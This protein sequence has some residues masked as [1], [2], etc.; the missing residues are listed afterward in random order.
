MC[1]RRHIRWGGLTLVLLLAGV[2]PVLAQHV[3]FEGGLD[4]R[5]TSYRSGHEAAA[6]VNTVGLGVTAQTTA[7]LIGRVLLQVEGGVDYLGP[8]CYDLG[9]DCTARRAAMTST[10]VASGAIGTG[11]QLPLLGTQALGVP[12]AGRVLLGREWLAG[13]IGADDCLNCATD[14]EL[15]G[16]PFLEGSLDVAAQPGLYLRLGYRTYAGSDRHGQ[17]VL[18][19]VAQQ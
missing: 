15:D 5:A 7:R 16:G 3:A 13:G 14:L 10:F 6:E 4:L 1:Y 18:G 17:V 19:V 2:S 8:L 9:T 11:V 12:V